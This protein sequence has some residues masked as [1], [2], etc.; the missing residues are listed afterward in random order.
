MRIIEIIGVGVEPRTKDVALKMKDD[1]NNSVEMRIASGIVAS[2]AVTLFSLANKR[3]P[4]M[5]KE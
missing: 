4:Q 5:T 1:R 3:S 2:I